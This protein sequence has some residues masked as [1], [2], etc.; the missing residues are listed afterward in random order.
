M[1]GHEIPS[2]REREGSERV[3]Y[4]NFQAQAG[5]I[6]LLGGQLDR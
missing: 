4:G 5:C 1:S 6:V 2:Y 3:I